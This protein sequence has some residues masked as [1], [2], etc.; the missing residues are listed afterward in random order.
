MTAAEERRD[1][2]KAS[3]FVSIRRNMHPTFLAI[4]VIGLVWAIFWIA[5]GVLALEKRVERLE[6]K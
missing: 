6:R 3:E 1:D 4:V 2:S 5:V